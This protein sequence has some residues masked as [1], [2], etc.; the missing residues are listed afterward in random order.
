MA[1]TVQGGSAT[2]YQFPAR[3]RYAVNGASNAAEHLS[4]AQPAN[5]MFGSGWYHDEAIE[6]ERTR[7][8]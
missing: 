6:T 3:G 2:V 7:K 4:A 5:I 8:N 1:T